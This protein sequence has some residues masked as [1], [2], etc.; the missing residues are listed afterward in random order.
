VQSREIKDNCHF[1][2]W[3][4]RSSEDTDKERLGHHGDYRGGAA[5]RNGGSRAQDEADLFVV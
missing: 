5:G 1:S 3:S 4:K 2:G